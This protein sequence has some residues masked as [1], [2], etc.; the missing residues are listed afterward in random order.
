MTQKVISY[1]GGAVD[2]IFE[3]LLNENDYTPL[4]EV[5]SG[6]RRFGNILDSLFSHKETFDIKCRYEL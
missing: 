3:T 4:D 1:F 6:I 2:T 5:I